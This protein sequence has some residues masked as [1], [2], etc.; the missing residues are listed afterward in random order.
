MNNYKI[1]CLVG[2]AFGL[3]PYIFVTFGEIIQ[4]SFTGYKFINPI[5]TD[6]FKLKLLTR[7]KHDL[8]L[9]S[10]NYQQTSSREY[11]IQE[12]LKFDS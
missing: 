9:E 5:Y 1:V 3:N 4:L 12:K 2:L 11:E 6:A 10:K 8:K 7:K